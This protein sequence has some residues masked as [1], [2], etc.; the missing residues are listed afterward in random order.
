M[1]HI[2]V[3]DDEPAIRNVLQMTFEADGTSRVST[4][5]S[6]EDAVEI[7]LHDRP[8]AAIIDA[9]LPC[10][11]GLTLARHMIGRGIPV[12]VMTGQPEY[13]RELEASGICCLAKPVSMRRVLV[14]TRLLLDEATRRMAQLRVGL[15]ELN[16]ARSELSRLLEDSRVLVARVQAEREE[17][18]I[19]KGGLRSPFASVWDHFVDEAIAAAGADHG[20]LQ[21]ADLATETLRIVASRGLAAPFL[22]FFAAVRALDDSTC[23]AAFKRGCRI[24]APDISHSTLFVG[25]ESGRV[26][27]EA[28]IQAVQSTP[29]LARDGRVIGVVETH[30]RTVWQPTEPELTG[31]DRVVAQIADA[32]EASE[33][34]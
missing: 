4:A 24:L 21:V 9:I 10:S 7:V 34:P 18:R 33:L 32:I 13:Q 31:L 26:L 1:R 19:A 30:W 27:R 15:M 6:A 23:G 3:V 20:M 28:G 8:D 5:G 12:L 25:K 29:A 17:R 2:L 11:S 22:D 16:E 14:E